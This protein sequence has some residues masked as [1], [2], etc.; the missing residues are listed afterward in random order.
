[1]LSSWCQK[2]PHF[3]GRN[4]LLKLL[5]QKLFDEKRKQY[6][7]RVALYGLGGVGKTQLAIEYVVTHE[8]H[9]DG[10]Y[11]I[12][13][14]DQAGLFSGFQKIAVITGCATTELE[15]SQLARVVLEWLG[16]QDRWL[17]VL[18]NMDDISVT[19]NYLPRLRAGGGHLL[20][21]T[22]DPNA[23]GIPAEGLEIGVLNVNDAKDLLLLRSNLYDDDVVLTQEIDNEA[24]W[25]V[26]T[27]GFLALAIEQAAAYIREQLK[28]IFKY[29]NVYSS[30]RKAL[31][32]RRTR[33]N[34]EYCGRAP[35]IN[36]TRLDST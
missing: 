13:T 22:C 20:I 35:A 16:K 21:T 1:M 4:N 2:N 24:I 5:H 15:P 12:T 11:W 9:Y 36:R 7:H 3:I 27:L 25:I 23:T 31:H 28:D 32:S 34:W 17:L 14:V 30:H 29:M 10:I 18:D 33:G 19:G 6:T 8:H 26:M